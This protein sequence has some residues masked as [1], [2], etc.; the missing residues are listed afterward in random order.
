MT[1]SR[2]VALAFGKRHDN[3]L[4]GIERM[5]ASR[6]QEIAHHARLNFEA[7][8]YQDSTGRRLPMYR[9]TAKGVSELAMSLT[10]DKSRVIRISFIRGTSLPPLCGRA[11]GGLRLP[12]KIAQIPRRRSAR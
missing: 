11:C 9:M 6:L 7:S 10:G 4:R 8:D 3:V 5:R 2:A 1:D 12:V